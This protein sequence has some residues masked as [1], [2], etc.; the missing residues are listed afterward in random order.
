MLLAESLEV[1]R[2]GLGDLG[3]QV[4]H[5]VARVIVEGL[6][7]LLRRNFEDLPLLVGN[8]A[9]DVLKPGFLWEGNAILFQQGTLGAAL[10]T[11]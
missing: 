2:I 5:L 7:V 1:G 4:G 11:P 6:P 10:G 8:E 9:E 3:F